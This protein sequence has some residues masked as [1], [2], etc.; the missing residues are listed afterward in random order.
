VDLERGLVQV[1]EKP[2]AGWTTKTYQERDV[3]VGPRLAAEL[4]RY[5][6][7]LPQEPDRWLFTSRVRPGRRLKELAPQVARLFRDAGVKLPRGGTHSLRK[8]WATKGGEEGDLEALRE[9][10]GW[11]SWAAMAHRVAAGA[12]RRAAD[13]RE[14]L[15]PARQ[16]NRDFGSDQEKSRANRQSLP[17]SVV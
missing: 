17:R 7:T 3:E 8:W 13:R 2:E 10:G 9:M 5:L 1:R 11:S 12:E 14:V 16:N 15:D 4:R 6:S